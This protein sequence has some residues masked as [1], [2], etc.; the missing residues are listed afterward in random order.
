MLRSS[1]TLPSNHLLT[2]AGL[3]RFAG[4]LLLLST[5]ACNQPLEP[6]CLPTL[7][8]GG[9]RLHDLHGASLFDSDL[10]FRQHEICHRPAIEPTERKVALRGNSTVF[11]LDVPVENCFAGLLNRRW[12]ASNE[13]A[14]IYNLACAVE[15]NARRDLRVAGL[16]V[17]DEA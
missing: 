10:I 16:R 2:R 15:P 14:H 13:S 12:T 11:G 4:L 17:Q 7:F 3:C 5:L 6:R 9:Q 1:S 8:E